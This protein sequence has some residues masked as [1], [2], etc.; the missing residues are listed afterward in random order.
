[1]PLLILD[2]DGVINE[3][4]DDYIRSLADW[5][6]VPGSIEAMARAL[7]ITEPAA[8]LLLEAPLG[9]LDEDVC[10]LQEIMAEAG[11]VVLD[12]F[13]VR[14]DAALVR[15]PNRYRDERGSGM[16]T[17]VTRLLAEVE[18]SAA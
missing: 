4:S 6:P 5:H 16:W 9:R 14:T 12:G 10:R 17:K 7:D 13:E 18:T 8:A 15:Y 1:M 11:R 3:D 2:R